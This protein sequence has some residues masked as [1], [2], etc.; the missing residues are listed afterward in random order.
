MVSAG[1]RFYKN[2]QSPGR[3]AA[4]LG[5]LFGLAGMSTSAVTVA[6]P[7]LAG[8]LHVTAGSPT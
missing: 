5:L 7:E 4:L 1:A 3:S 2:V 8:E 6:L